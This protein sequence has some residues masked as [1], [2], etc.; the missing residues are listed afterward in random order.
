MDKKK[1][2][3]AIGIFCAFVLA[4]G[5]FAKMTFFKSDGTEKKG[6]RLSTPNVNEEEIKHL[7]KKE[8]YDLEA[9]QMQNN[10]KK[11]DS[12][13]VLNANNDFNPF[14][15]VNQ[16]AMTDQ[17]TQ[18]N[19]IEQQQ[20]AEELR[21]LLEMQ[22]EM[23]AQAR[24][25][26]MNKSYENSMTG[27]QFPD[28][29]DTIG[30]QPVYPASLADRWEENKVW[31]NSFKGLGGMSS[32]PPGLDLVAAET[33]DKGILVSGSTVAIRLKEAV[34]IQE[35]QLIIP[36]DEVLYGKTSFDSENR[37]QINI[38]SYKT[39]KKIYDLALTVYDFDGREGIHLGNKTWPKIPSKVAKEVY[40]YVRQKGTQVSTFG[41]QD[42][43]VEADEIRRI[44]LLSTINEVLE[45]LLNKKKVFMPRKYHLW[46]NIEANENN[47]R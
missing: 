2:V 44:A 13:R 18:M 37:L 42:T 12:L 1:K 3:I 47:L 40:S 22:E 28:D 19:S 45:E 38:I 9:R 32:R 7:T 23:D 25:E 10:K 5:V 24:R 46:I 21:L 29:V 20:A 17:I 8:S 26:L 11:R 14:K 35:K 31:Q 30:E 6:L 41:G 4:V 15:D 27:R 39:D 34:H 36:K 43:E 16:S 33:V